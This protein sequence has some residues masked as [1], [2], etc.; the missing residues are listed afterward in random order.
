MSNIV[1]FPGAPIQR[2]ER[3]VFLNVSSGTKGDGRVICLL[4]SHRS[5]R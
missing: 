5:E 1:P 2:P 3:Q 4:T